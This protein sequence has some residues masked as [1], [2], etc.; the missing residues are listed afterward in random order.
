M[1]I[2]NPER[3]KK[4]LIV[5][6]IPP[7]TLKAKNEIVPLLERSLPHSLHRSSTMEM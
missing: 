5:E 2:S 6:R 7:P 4:D 1:L 3:E